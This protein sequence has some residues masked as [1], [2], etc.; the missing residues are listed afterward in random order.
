MLR[1]RLA[2]ILFL[3]IALYGCNITRKVPSS[4]SLLVENIIKTDYAD[5]TKRDERIPSV[6]F[7]N[8]IPTSQTPNKRILGI[9][10]YLNAYNREDSTKHNMLQ[11]LYKKIGEAPTI[12]DSLKSE[13]IIRDMM[14]FAKSYGFYSVAISDSVKIK[15]DRARV[16]YNINAGK[17]TTI[18][19]ITYNF[20]DSTI[21]NIVIADGINSLIKV[22]KPLNRNILSDER[23]RIST[24]VRDNGYYKFST[25][26]IS[27]II[28]TLSSQY[29]A[30]VTINIGMKENQGFDANQIY[31]VNKIYINSN[32]D[33]FDKEQ[34]KLDTIYQQGMY[35][36]KRRGIDQN[37]RPELLASL[38]TI[39]S[40]NIY[41]QHSVD[42]TSTNLSNL[43]LFK[44]VN[45]QFEE[46]QRATNNLMEFRKSDSDSTIQHEVKYIDCTIEC[47]PTL[48]QSYSFGGEISSNA[49]Y[50]DFSLSLGYGNKNLFKSTTAFD[51]T[52][53]GAYDIMHSSAKSNSYEYGATTGLSWSRL[54]LPFAFK[55]QNRTARVSTRA[56]LVYNN[57]NRPLYHRITSGGSF[58]YQWDRRGKSSFIFNP[59]NLAYIRVPWIDQDYW[60]S[61]TNK[62]LS[63]SYYSQLI[64]GMAGSYI[65]TNQN[66]LSPIT[67]TLKV[68][69]ESSGNFLTLAS[70]ILRSTEYTDESGVDYYNAFGVRYAEYIRGDA[71]YVLNLRVK[72][73]GALVFRVLG[74]YGYAYGNSSYIP[75]EKM[76]FSGG[77]S[78][79]RGWQVRMLGPGSTE[80]PSSDSYPEQVGNIKFEANVE[81]RFP[82]AGVLNGAIFLDCGNIWLN[83]IGC[84]TDGEF[85]F[86]SFSKQL[87]LNSGI[88]ARFDFEF[89]LL[90]L[91]W[92]IQLRNPGWESGKEWIRK[93]DI[94]NS[95]IHFGLGYPF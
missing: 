6:E 13:E 18:K 60:D 30:A 41:S 35:V 55:K 46:S 7:L 23:N 15:R 81:S 25:R 65:F 72:E 19:S 12:Y 75:F 82:I 34:L 61:M 42:Q 31:K 26:E 8:F 77:A 66:S 20:A 50:T 33:P 84:D 2:Y 40:N 3:L 54:I 63:N 68:N 37:I 32:Y 4:S 22:G 80:E 88:G 38:L 71:S 9:P 24:S 83:G 47:T 36:I 43:R 91:D 17:V 94:N 64:L 10:L 29:R 70:S 56:E 92:G 73:R 79:M 58:G 76:F 93:F 69:G 11:N 45:I 14:I 27:F 1:K 78:S 52:F 59:L 85:K 53:K 87:A 51:I 89:F 44:R 28:D 21:A 16:T 39:K 95:A 5:S 62:Y 57:Q 49:N 48:R 67:H 86:N 74:G 90:R